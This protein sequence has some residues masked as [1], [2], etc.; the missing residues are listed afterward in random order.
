M[1]PCLYP[2]KVH[3][4]FDGR[5]AS[6]NASIRTLVRRLADDAA[7]LPGSATRSNRFYG[8]LQALDQAVDRVRA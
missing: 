7:S 8:S 6:C 1:F 5:Q 2:S 4:V 3:E